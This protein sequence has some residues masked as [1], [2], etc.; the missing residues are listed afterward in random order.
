MNLPRST[1][2]PVFLGPYHN[3]LRP[4]NSLASYTWPNQMLPAKFL[5]LLFSSL[6]LLRYHHPHPYLSHIISKTSTQC[7][8][9]FQSFFLFMFFF[10]IF[11]RVSSMNKRSMITI[12]WNEDDSVWYVR[13]HVERSLI[14]LPIGI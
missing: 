4:T 8:F 6:S 2:R 3:S 13:K 1:V 7:I 10:S 11:K 14:V 9:S 5:H 12:P